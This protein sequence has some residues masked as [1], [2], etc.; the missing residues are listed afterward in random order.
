MPT[1]LRIASF[2]F[3]F[4]SDEGNEP[5]HIHVRGAAGECKFWLAP[6]ALARNRGL[7]PRD[8]REIERLVFEN[9]Q[10]LIDKYH[11]YHDH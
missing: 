11:E 8:L 4:Y 7:A 1:I 6:V 3:H 10:L 2:R 9:E 5:T